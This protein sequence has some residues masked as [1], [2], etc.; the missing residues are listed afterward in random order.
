VSEPPAIPKADPVQERK[1]R[2]KEKAARLGD[3]PVESEASVLVTLR[4]PL[5]NERI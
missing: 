3:E 4:K 1:E 2:L 5:G